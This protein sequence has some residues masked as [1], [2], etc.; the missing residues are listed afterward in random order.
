VPVRIV[1]EAVMQRPLGRT[2][3]SGAGAAEGGSLE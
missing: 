3:Q 1:R 2:T